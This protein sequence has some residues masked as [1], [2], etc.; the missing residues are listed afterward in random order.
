MF[1]VS[2]YAISTKAIQL[3]TSVSHSMYPPPIP[4]L[5]EGG[6]EVAKLTEEGGLSYLA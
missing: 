3:T 5:L 4:L 2:V 1:Y 6:W